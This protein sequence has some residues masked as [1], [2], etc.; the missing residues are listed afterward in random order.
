VRGLA[1]AIVL[2]ARTVHADDRPWAAGVSAEA[3][4]QA[5]AAYNEANQ[6]FEDGAYS[7][8]LEKYQAALAIWDH[9]KIH[10][11][12]AVCLMNLDRT[13]EAYE[14]L[15][16]ALKYG[17]APFDPAMFKQAQ[18]YEKLLSGKVAELELELKQDGA[19]RSASMAR[20]CSTSRA[21]PRCT[22][23]PAS[24]TS[25]SRPSQATRRRPARSR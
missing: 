1:V 2:L 13:V 24:R 9:P 22:C 21:R 19:R 16:A 10:Y 6:L 4:Q 5:L 12:T 25:S 14:Q 23:S 11:N 7:K 15:E 8:A 18:L 17:P 20:S 3:Q